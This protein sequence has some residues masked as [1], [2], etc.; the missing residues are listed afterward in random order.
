MANYEVKSYAVNPVEGDDQIEVVIH[1]T[2]G[3]TWEYGIPYNPTTGR[4]MFE[5]IDVLAMDF[6]EE[7]AEELTD[8]LDELV[9]E[10]CDL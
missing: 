8:K 2:D 10:L 9:A 3:S 7:F 1:A 6:G 5:E 4:Y